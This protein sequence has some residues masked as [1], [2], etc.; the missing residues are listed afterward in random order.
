MSSEPTKEQAL[1]RPENP[2]TTD[3]AIRYVGYAARIKTILFSAK[4]YLAYS[5]DFGEAFR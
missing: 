3:S 1:E 4:R 5:S 2:H